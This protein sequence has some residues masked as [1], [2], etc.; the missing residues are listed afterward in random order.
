MIAEIRNPNCDGAYCKSTAGPVRRLPTSPDSAAI[1]CYDC[2]RH[3]LE[4][5]RDR[6]RELGDDGLF[7]LPAWASLEIY[8]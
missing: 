2:Y 1:L 3:E 6:I 5:R 7:D 4:W 8:E